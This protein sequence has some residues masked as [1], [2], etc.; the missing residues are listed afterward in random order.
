[1]NRKYWLDL[2]TGITW[3]EFLEHGA[4]V[5]GFR[6]RRKNIVKN[7]HPGDYFICYL[8]GI[9]RFIAVLE[10]QSECYFDES[11]IFKNETFPHRFK[12]K[13][14]HRL[15][16]K[17]AV[18]V[19]ILK[20]K[21]SLFENLKSP[22][23]WSGFF[24]GSPVEFN[25]DDAKIIIEAI[26]QAETNPIE[27]EFD[28]R[29]YYSQPKQYGSTKKIVPEKQEP[30]IKSIP[31]KPLASTRIH[32]EIQ[33]L[34]LKLGSDMNLDVWVAKNDRNREFNGISFQ[35]IPRLKRELPRQFDNLTNKIIEMIDVLWL[36]GDAI[37]AAFEVE[38]ST[39]IYSGLLRMSDLVSMQP[40]I[41][42]NLY[43][44]APDERRGKVLEEINRPTFAK[45]N[46]SLPR[47]CRFIPYSR[48]KNEI[49]QLGSKVK[50]MRLD[51]ID[52]LAENCQLD[53]LNV[54]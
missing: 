35:T 22:S 11:V 16:P 3:E 43:L 9:S 34:L 32:D 5:S 47:I 7:I 6:E 41:N 15:E 10:V 33:Y 21:L 36:R 14:V 28:P 8:T 51:F 50:Y 2:F 54:P 1:M 46:P 23:V 40:N 26:K 18:P 20:D 4:N 17:T 45:L 48:L 12:V 49:E 37:V 25:I 30:E 31:E 52:E 24:R 44:V 13:L 27:R 53:K 38:H 29:K 19:S 42:L 39:S